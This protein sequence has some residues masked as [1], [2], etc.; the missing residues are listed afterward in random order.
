VADDLEA[1]LARAERSLVAHDF[2]LR[3]LL[4]HLAIVDSQAYGALIGGFTHS[5]LYSSSGT[6]G[7]LTR[8]IA[9]QLTTML[10][11]I[12]GSLPARR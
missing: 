7:E 8:E 12:A 11:D 3:A 9:D 1:R 6:A 4:T 10:E 5:R 2:L